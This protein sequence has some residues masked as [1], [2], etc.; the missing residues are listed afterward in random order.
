M[1][2][3]PTPLT[4]DIARTDFTCLALKAWVITP[5]ALNR[6][7]SGVGFVGLQLV[8]RG[9]ADVELKSA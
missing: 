9:I 8:T 6:S 5:F 7:T 2:I 1:I 3:K 4:C